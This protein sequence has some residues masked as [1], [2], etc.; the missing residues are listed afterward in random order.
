MSQADSM[1]AHRGFTHS[2][3]FAFL[4]S[5]L[6]AWIFARLHPNKKMHFR[7]WFNLFFVNLI[8]HNLIDGMTSY[9]TAWFEPFS[10]IRVSLQALFVADPFYTLPLLIA[11]FALLF[12]RKSSRRRA[13]WARFG[14]IV[15]TLYV[16]FAFTNKYKV[17]K[18]FRQELTRQDKPYISYFTTPAPLN[19]FLWYVVAQNDS[20]YYTGYYSIFDRQPDIAMGFQPRNDFLLA[21]LPNDQ[22]LKTLKRFSQGYYTLEDDSG[23]IFFNDIRFGTTGG[24]DNPNAGFVF[25]FGLHKDAN[26]DLV[27]QR[28]RFKGAGKDALESLWNRMWGN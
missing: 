26:N 16:C 4:A 9:G 17:D 12:L 24:W 14:L 8:I 10:H 23:K 5:P 19:N 2:F 3:V 28:G 20:G 1:L 11:F 6:L 22:D 21:S 15:S 13:S 27:I 18:H 25:R 7:D